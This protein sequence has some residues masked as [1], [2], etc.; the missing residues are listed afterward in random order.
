V[1]LFENI[2]LLKVQKTFIRCLS[3]P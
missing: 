1:H 3:V 2:A